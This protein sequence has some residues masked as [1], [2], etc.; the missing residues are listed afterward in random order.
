M[1]EQEQ[2]ALWK[3]VRRKYHRWSPDKANGYVH[4]VMDEGR[5]QDPV[6]NQVVNAY[7]TK[8]DGKAL[9][10][11]WGYLA[12]FADAR[13]VDVRPQQWWVDH[14]TKLEYRWWEVE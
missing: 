11:A 7:V 13:G 3:K 10:Y 9:Q 8:G 1:N 6:P 4:G 14:G 5:Y 12:G 2:Q